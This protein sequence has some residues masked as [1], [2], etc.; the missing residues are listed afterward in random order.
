MPFSGYYLLCMLMRSLS[1]TIDF[2]LFSDP[3][4]RIHPIPLPQK[5]PVPQQILGK[6]MTTLPTVRQLLIC[7]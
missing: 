1:L 2:H 6:S 7:S 3:L 5:H 4:M